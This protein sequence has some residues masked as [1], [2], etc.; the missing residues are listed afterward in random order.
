[1]SG[2]Y[3]IINDIAFCEESCRHLEWDQT[4]G[5]CLLLKKELSFYDWFVAECANPPPPPEKPP[6]P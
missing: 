2:D 4:D 3:T 5:W 6:E 1:V